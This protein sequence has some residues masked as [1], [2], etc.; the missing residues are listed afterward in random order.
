MWDIRSGWLSCHMTRRCIFFIYFAYKET[1]ACRFKCFFR[2]NLI[3]HFLCASTRTQFNELF[4]YLCHK[5]SNFFL[6]VVERVAS[7]MC[8]HLSSPHV[9]HRD[10]FVTLARRL[11]DLNTIRHK[12]SCIR[13]GQPTLKFIDLKNYEF[14]SPVLELGQ[15]QEK[16]KS[17]FTFKTS[18]ASWNSNQLNVEKKESKLR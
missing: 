9:N 11:D 8:I 12:I 7:C 10:I 17:A 16:K 13:E 5:K 2:V 14:S 4:R 18:E 3:H 15:S 1:R 6:F